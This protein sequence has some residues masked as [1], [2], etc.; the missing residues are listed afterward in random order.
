VNNVSS[1][2]KA[3]YFDPNTNGQPFPTLQENSLL[4]N[5]MQLPQALKNQYNAYL[6]SIGQS[7]V[8]KRSGS[9][10]GGVIPNMFSLTPF[11]SG[12]VFYFYQLDNQ[13]V[14]IKIID[15]D[16]TDEA[17]STSAFNAGMAQVKSL[18][19]TKLIIDIA[20]NVGGDVCFMYSIMLYFF[21][22]GYIQPV[23]RLCNDFV[24]TLSQAAVTQN[25]MDNPWNPGLYIQTTNTSL[26]PDYYFDEAHCFNSTYKDGNYTTQIRFNCGYQ[27][28]SN[29]T[30]NFTLNNI[31]FL[32]NGL[33]AS[34]CTT[35][36]RVARP[37]SKTTRIYG[38]APFQNQ[39]LNVGRSAGGSQYSLSEFL[40]DVTELGINTTSFDPF[41]VPT[42]LPYNGDLTFTLH[43]SY[44]KT[45]DTP[46]EFQFLQVNVN[47]P[48]YLNATYDPSVT[49]KYIASKLPGA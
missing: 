14:V 11:A 12:G 10:S 49:W 8:F 33:C 34:A 31:A 13:T 29:F 15:F 7:P 22:A 26:I 23:D 3:C 38:T 18:G 37:Y 30:Y 25:R 32:T 40:G 1:L 24:A 46:S 44:Y 39:L 6:V 21:P 27:P 28:I 20:D 16:S 2:V 41:L 45:A 35:A 36:L 17:L 47:L 5:D 42:P 9:D 48:M 19:L 43:E 4:S